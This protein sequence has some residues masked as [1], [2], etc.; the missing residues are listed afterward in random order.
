MTPA[1]V[2]PLAAAGEDDRRMTSSVPTLT[3]D[4]STAQPDLAGAGPWGDDVV[5]LPEA[6][7]VACRAR[8][9]AGG[10]AGRVITA[11][12]IGAL[13]MLAGLVLLAAALLGAGT[14]D[15]LETGAVAC[16]VSGA[17][18]VAASEERVPAAPARARRVA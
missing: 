6:P 7:A 12:R 2:L 9:S 15:L 10:A 3:L 4:P 1:S 5:V 18:L 8:A 11:A 16:V 14:E 17:V 13:M